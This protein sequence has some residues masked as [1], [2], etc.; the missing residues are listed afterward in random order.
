MR[1]TIISGAARSQSKSN[2]AKIIG[3]F[4]QGFQ[5]RENVAEIWYL[6]DRRQ[7]ESAK[8]AM[9]TE[10]NV[11][12]ALPLYVENVPGI[13]LEFLAG[14][15][16]DALPQ[17]RGRLFARHGSFQSPDFAPLSSPEYLS[18]KQI[19]Q[20]RRL[21]PVQKCLLSVI[22]KRLGCKTRLDARPLLE[23]GCQERIKP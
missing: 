15:A 4:C 12:I 18:E 3:A 21:R 7:W 8:K 16:A 22:A 6:S 11:L 19:R 5:S 2:T 1:L 13:L 17:T 23:N 14:V 9:L 20:S 10:E